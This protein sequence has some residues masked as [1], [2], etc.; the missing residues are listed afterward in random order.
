MGANIA[1]STY[2]LHSA[3]TICS[4]CSVCTLRLLSLG[5][6]AQQPSTYSLSRPISL[7]LSV[8][9]PVERG[10]KRQHEGR[11]RLSAPKAFA[12]TGG[13]PPQQ[14]RS[15]GCPLR[16]RALQVLG[17]WLTGYLLARSSLVR[18][19]CAPI[20]AHCAVRPLGETKNMKHPHLP[21]SDCRCVYARATRVCTSSPSRL[22]PVFAPTLESASV[23][24]QQRLTLRVHP[25][26][27]LGRNAA[28]LHSRMSS[29]LF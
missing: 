1:S 10:S 14:V 29:L 2:M 27:F 13:L 20:S 18:V 8:A 24:Y 15:N 17:Y 7:L 4:L 12:S 22:L 19:W 9:S 3:R 28:P 5:R 21:Q 16:V 23:Q 26:R 25:S 6:P 11:L